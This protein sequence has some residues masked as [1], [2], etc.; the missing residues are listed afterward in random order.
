VQ[1]GAQQLLRDHPEKAAPLMAR[2]VREGLA[3]SHA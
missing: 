2:W 3:F 1:H